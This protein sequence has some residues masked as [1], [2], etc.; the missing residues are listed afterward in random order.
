MVWGWNADLEGPLATHVFLSW[1]ARFDHCK[2]EICFCVQLVELAEAFYKIYTQVSRSPLRHSNAAPNKTPGNWPIDYESPCAY[3]CNDFMCVVRT[4]NKHSIEISGCI[5]YQMRDWGW[6]GRL[7]SWV[8]CIGQLDIMEIG[9]WTGK[10]ITELNSIITFLS[11]TNVIALFNSENHD[12]NWMLAQS[13]AYAR[14]NGALV[15]QVGVFEY[16][17][18]TIGSTRTRLSLRPSVG[19]GCNWSTLARRWKCNLEK[20]VFMPWY[21]EVPRSTIE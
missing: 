8:S 6:L 3:A 5:R 19:Q 2:S 21:E 14:V 16:H 15:N 11:L 9:L 1:I 4:T 20:V 7:G 10:V 13:V 17:C 18:M 12:L